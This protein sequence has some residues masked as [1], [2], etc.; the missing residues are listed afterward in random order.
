MPFEMD[1]LE[2]LAKDWELMAYK[3]RWFRSPMDTIKQKNDL[4]DLWDKWEAKG[5]FGNF[6]TMRQIQLSDKWIIFFSY[7]VCF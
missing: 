2:N 5:K 6:I 4:N 3:H 1:P 7:F